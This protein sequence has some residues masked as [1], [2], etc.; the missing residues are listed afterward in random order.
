MGTI[1][2]D[3]LEPQSGT[4]LTLGASGDTVKVA[5]G[6]T[7]NVGIAMTDM[8]RQNADTAISA[9]STTVLASN[10][11]QVDDAAFGSIGSAM[12]QSSGIFT[13]PST[14]IYLVSFTIQL[15]SP[16]Q[17]ATYAGGLIDVT[18]NNS[19]YVTTVQGYQA[20]YHSNGYGQ[21]TIFQYVDVTDTSNV[22]V[23]FKAL[24]EFDGDVIGA[25]NSSNTYAQFIRLGDT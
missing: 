21:V 24:M 1:F 9:G 15:H 7:N 2:V 8:W 25:T 23:R 11:E 16:S 12:T 20:I 13:F 3:N 18:Q 10:W 17:G 14:G 5:S 6:V 4:S 22:K 19:T